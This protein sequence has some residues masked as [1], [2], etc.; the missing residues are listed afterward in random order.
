MMSSRDVLGRCL[1]GLMGGEDGGMMR[2]RNG[3][4][5]ERRTWV[6]FSRMRRC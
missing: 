6:I 4:E 5:G 1:M 3:G 2:R